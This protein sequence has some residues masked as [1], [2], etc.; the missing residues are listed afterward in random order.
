[1]SD[2]HNDVN[3]HH[4]VAYIS[5]IL[6]TI[7]IIVDAERSTHC[8]NGST[9]ASFVPYQI[10][11]THISNRQALYMS[12]SVDA[13]GFDQLSKLIKSIFLE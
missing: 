2:E 11:Q 5:A 4:H 10:M 7:I 12:K 8:Q 13:P 9:L 3:G 1:M 6:I